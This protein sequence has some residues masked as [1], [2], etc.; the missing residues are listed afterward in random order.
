MEY[1]LVFVVGLFIGTKL[2]S[3][4]IGKNQTINQ[5]FKPKQKS[6]FR[7]RLDEALEEAKRNQ[8]KN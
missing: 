6:K 8:E 4:Y 7:D 1:I 5:D 3:I 2:N